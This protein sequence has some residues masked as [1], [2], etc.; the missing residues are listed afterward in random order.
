MSTIVM[1]AKDEVIMKLVHYFVT[2][3][4]Y[5]PIVVNGVK[6]EIW[7]EN[8]DGPYRIVRINSNNIFNTEQLDYD[9]L[10]INSI[11][12]QIKKK[13]LSFKVN[14]LSIML[15]VNEDLN[16]EGAKNV[17][18]VPI[19]DNNLEITDKKILDAFPDINEKLMK[20]TNGLD[21]IINV[22]QDINTKTEEDNRRFDKVFSPKKIIVTPFL[23]IICVIMFILTIVL[24]DSNSFISADPKVLLSL[25]GNLT[26]YLKDGEFWRLFTYM[27]LH[28]SIMHLLINMYS[29]YVIGTQLETFIGKFKF[30]FVFIISGI[31]G[32]LLSAIATPFLNPG[33]NVVSVGA[34]GAIFGL[35]AALLYFGYH[36]RTYLGAALKTQLLPIIGANLVIGFM[37][38]GIDNACHIGGLIGGFLS[39]MIVGIDQNSKMFERISGA[40]CLTIYIIFAYFI[41][42]NYI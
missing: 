8:Q 10:K 6:D 25:G 32:G 20:D 31:C 40:I 27:F 5:N 16:L 41:L 4:N 42:M 22:T 37:T 9:Y 34:S 13:T 35:V 2:E 1:D 17:D 18:Y 39:I 19:Y 33:K 15:N 38:V 30:M 36:Y 14:T 3:G 21:L 12:K 28:G 7:L 23:M 24:A 11:S 26:L 29:L